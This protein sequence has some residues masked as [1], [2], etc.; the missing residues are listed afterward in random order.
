MHS[1][2]AGQNCSSGAEGCLVVREGLGPLAGPGSNSVKIG[3]IRWQVADV[4]GGI[5]ECFG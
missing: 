3:K 4:C 5:V 2:R 1:V